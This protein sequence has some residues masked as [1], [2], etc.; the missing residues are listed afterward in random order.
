MTKKRKA[1]LL[2]AEKEI[3][4]NNNFDPIKDNIKSLTI[5]QTLRYFTLLKARDRDLAQD[6][7]FN[8]VHT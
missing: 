2:E 1:L 4:N 3:I 7:L 6:I 8:I 5:E